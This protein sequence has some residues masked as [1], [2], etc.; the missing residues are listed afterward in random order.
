M[1]SETSTFYNSHCFTTI[2]LI[3]WS[4]SCSLVSFTLWLHFSSAFVAETHG[5]SAAQERL[6]D[7]R[8]RSA[9]SLGVGRGRYR[10]HSTQPRRR[11]RVSLSTMGK[12]IELAASERRNSE[13]TERR[14]RKIRAK[15]S[16]YVISLLSIEWILY[17]N[18]FSVLQ[19]ITI[20]LKCPQKNSRF[21]MSHS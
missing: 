2:V 13:Q 20:F 8:A 17:F 3:L 15:L 4:S 1:F 10:R 6:G 14:E 21:F 11:L 18:V 12:P 9:R 5:G 7:A 16:F 19:Q